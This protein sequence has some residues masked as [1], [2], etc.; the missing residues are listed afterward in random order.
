LKPPE[1][2]GQHFF[3]LTILVCLAPE[4]EKSGSPVLLQV[5]QELCAMLGAGVG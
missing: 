4:V 1:T 5:V 3:L 2:R